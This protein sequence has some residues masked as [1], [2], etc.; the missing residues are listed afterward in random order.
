M[1][2]LIPNPTSKTKPRQPL[3]LGAES[4]SSPQRTSEPADRRS[5]FAAPSS[6]FRNQTLEKILKRTKIALALPGLGQQRLSDIGRGWCPLPVSLAIKTGR[7]NPFRHRRS[8]PP[9]G[10]WAGFIGGIPPS[11][12]L[13]TANHARRRADKSYFIGVFRISPKAAANNSRQ[14]PQGI[15]GTRFAPQQRAAGRFE[16]ENRRP[17][18]PR[19]PHPTEWLGPAT[20]LSS[21]LPSSP[22]S[23]VVP[24]QAEYPE[25]Q[26]LQ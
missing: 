11:Q 3:L 6:C 14:P 22:P 21:K 25:P 17:L 13:K 20:P 15:G 4:A 5:P 7:G 16:P 10:K 9:A 1:I 23:F 18:R 19:L 26:R 8:S 12:G 24:A 2:S